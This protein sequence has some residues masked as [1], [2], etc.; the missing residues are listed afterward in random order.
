MTINLP[1]NKRTYLFTFARFGCQCV[2]RTS[3]DAAIFCPTHRA[4]P[5]QAILVENL[6]FRSSHPTTPDVPN[7]VRNRYLPT[8]PA[9]LQNN[10]RNSI[11][12]E[13]SILGGRQEEWATSE[14]GE[15]GL[16]AA[17]LI[18]NEDIHE[19]LIAAC[20]CPDEQCCY[21]WCGLLTGLHAYWR[22][23][24]QGRS[25]EKTGIPEPDIFRHG[26]YGEMTEQVVQALD[27]ERRAMELALPTLVAQFKEARRQAN[28]PGIQPDHNP[29]LTPWLDSE[30][31]DLT[32]EKRD[33][34]TSSM[35]AR[36]LERKLLRLYAL[37]AIPVA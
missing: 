23:H 2:Y 24:A 31:R 22:L 12:T 27:A 20:E 33:P 21:R 8:H 25:E 36:S 29:Y 28:Q 26:S 14:Q 37:G 9:F 6:E 17:C 30:Y 15:L 4:D 18:D 34:R 16:C 11:H 1:A 13:L 19:T 35:V 3:T 7:L 32:Q 10:S 5:E